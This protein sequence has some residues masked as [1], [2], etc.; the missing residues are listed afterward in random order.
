MIGEG[1]WK[2]PGRLSGGGESRRM[3]RQKIGC[4]KRI[5]GGDRGY[6]NKELKEADR[7]G[8]VFSRDVLRWDLKE[9]G[10]ARG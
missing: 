7:R 4:D 10:C 8:R 3:Q 6:P 1:R 5:T 2:P 9:E